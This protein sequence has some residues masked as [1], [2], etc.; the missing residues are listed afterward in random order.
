MQLS[1]LLGMACTPCQVAP[2]MQYLVEGLGPNSVYAY[3]LACGTAAA[4][5]SQVIS[6]A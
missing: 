2:G 5:V 1:T 6:T 4:H 3:K